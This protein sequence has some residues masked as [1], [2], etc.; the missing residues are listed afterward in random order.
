MTWRDVFSNSFATFL[1]DQVKLLL[2]I[3]CEFIIN[4]VPMKEVGYAE[5]G[6]REGTELLEVVLWDC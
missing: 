5:Y 2:L 3:C 1:M 6:T 4:L